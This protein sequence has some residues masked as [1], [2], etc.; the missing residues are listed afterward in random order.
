MISSAP[1]PKI[2]PDDVV[3]V[4]C[5]PLDLPAARLHGFTAA[6]DDD[7]RRQW[8]RMR[9]GGDQ[10][11]ASR[12]ARRAVLASYL[13]VPASS[14]RFVTDALGKPRLADSPALHFNASARGGMA[15]IAVAAD[16]A[17]GVDVECEQTLPLTTE[18]LEEMLTRDEQ[19][20]IASTPA[21][22]RR[23]AFSE[24]WTRHEAVR[25]ALGLALEDPLPVVADVATRPVSAP[26]GYAVS[27]AA[28]GRWSVRE[29]DFGS[30]A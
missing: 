14:L 13:G 26:E 18:V 7:E 20:R 22:E 25:K 3:D 4:W 11:A 2:P 23:H 5:V 30:L 19:A 16:R 10:W 12:A 29:R 9:V 28:E 8:A 21:G 15:V 17:V 1:A 6:L 24:A 27:V